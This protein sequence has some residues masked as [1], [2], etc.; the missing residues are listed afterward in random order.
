[1][2]SQEEIRRSAPRR[3]DTIDASPA[4]LACPADVHG[5]TAAL[6]AVLASEEFGRADAVAFAN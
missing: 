2:E 1:M 5:D 4:V 3:V 6:D